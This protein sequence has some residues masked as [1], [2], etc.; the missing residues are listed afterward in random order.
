LRKIDLPISRP[1]SCAFGGDALDQLFITS[2]RTGLSDAQLGLEPLAGS[3]F[4][5]QPG[6]HGWPQPGFLG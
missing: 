6:V 5:T 4:V 1:T 2:A 3:L